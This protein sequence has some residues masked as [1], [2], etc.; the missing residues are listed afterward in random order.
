[1]WGYNNKLIKK[2]HVGRRKVKTRLKMFDGQGEFVLLSWSILN[3]KMLTQSLKNSG[4]VKKV[5][6]TY[7]RDA[8]L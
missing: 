1:M 2:K 5:R 3:S 6:V 4:S 7:R 8:V